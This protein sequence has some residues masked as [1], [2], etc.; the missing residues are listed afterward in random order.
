MKIAAMFIKFAIVLALILCRLLFVKA[1]KDKL[2][3]F[4]QF[5][6][7]VITI[8]SMLRQGILLKQINCLNVTEVTE[9]G[10]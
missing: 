10:N 3:F 2:T 1:K 4:F 9:K 6:K 5:A 8:S 7:K